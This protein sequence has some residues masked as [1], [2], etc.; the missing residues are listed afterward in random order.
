MPTAYQ[1]RRDNS[2]GGGGGGDDDGGGKMSK[3][4]LEQYQKDKNK[5]NKTGDS[6]DAE[7]GDEDSDEDEI[8]NNNN[9]QGLA[10][11]KTAKRKKKRKRKTTLNADNADKQK[12]K[13][14]NVDNHMG[15]VLKTE[16]DSDDDRQLCPRIDYYNF[17]FFKMLVVDVQGPLLLDVLDEIDSFNDENNPHRGQSVEGIRNLL[18]EVCTTDEEITTLF[19]CLP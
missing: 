9:G 13:A 19:G 16:S 6:S 15:D 8:N 4:D 18:L 14:L 7:G 2:G 1:Q 11:S 12:R 17:W 5:K 3:E 10:F